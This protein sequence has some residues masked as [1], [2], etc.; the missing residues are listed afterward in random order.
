MSAA[1]GQP[2]NGDER[3]QVDDTQSYEPDPMVGVGWA[4]LVPLHPLTVPSA[5]EET[6]EWRPPGE[7]NRSARLGRGHHDSQTP[8]ADSDIPS[9]EDR[10]DAMK[11]AETRALA[12]TGP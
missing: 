8:T 2:G 5:P 12:S 7:C 10:R 9:V 6:T 4:R 1:R 11:S 3:T